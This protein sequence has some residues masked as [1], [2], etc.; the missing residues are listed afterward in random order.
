MNSSEDDG[1]SHPL[2]LPKQSS[3]EEVSSALEDTLSDSSLLRFERLRRGVLLEFSSLFRLAAPACVV[4]LLGNVVS[5]S[6]QI[7]CGHISNLAL[8]AASLGNNGIQ[9]FAYGIMVINLSS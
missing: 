6:T 9:L 4:Y 1:I 3:R 5:L 7:F 2:L 8:A